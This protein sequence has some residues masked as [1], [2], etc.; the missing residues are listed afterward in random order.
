M[1]VLVLGGTAEARELAAALGTVAELSLAGATQ[2]PLSL[3]H[4]I[5]GFGGAN[6]L[7]AYLSTKGYNGVIDA[8]HPFAAQMSRNAYEATLSLNMPLLRLERPPWPSKAAWKNV[9]DMLGAAKA[10]PAAASVF[11]SIGS[12]SLGPFLQRDDIWCLTRSIEPPVQAPPIGE[13]LLERP[14]FTLAHE[15]ALMQHHNISHLVSKNAGGEATY[16]KIRAAN[17]LG[18]QVIMVKRPQLPEALT[19]ETVAEAVK[20]V[21]NLGE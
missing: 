9:P 18:I 4:R 17:T 15:L 5:G 13:V 1:T 20:W 12:Q 2:K 11:L 14:P 21:E 19:V 3:P 7:A 10:T 16:A 6:G 8:T